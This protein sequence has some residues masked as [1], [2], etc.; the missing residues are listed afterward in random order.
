ML[1]TTS[2]RCRKA[3]RTTDSRDKLE[4]VAVLSRRIAK[5]S[6]DA[7]R[8]TGS[9]R[10]LEPV[11]VLSSEISRQRVAAWRV[12][13]S[14]GRGRWGLCELAL[15]S[16]VLCACS[17]A[18]RPVA[19]PPPASSA[20][21]TTTVTQP[22]A[23]GAAPDGAAVI[24]GPDAVP[25]PTELQLL[26]AWPIEGPPGV[27][28][29]EFQ[30]SG[31]LWARGRL[32]AVSDRQD[33]VVFELCDSGAELHAR[34]WLEFQAP[35]LTGQVPGR[36][37]FEGLAHDGGGALLL[38]SEARFGVL[39]VLEA[40]PGGALPHAGRAA[41]L[42]ARDGAGALEPE[43]PSLRELGHAA[44]FFGVPGADLEGITLLPDGG[45][46][47]AAERQPRG[48]IELGPGRES[49]LQVWDMARSAWP[50]PGARPADFSDLSAADGRVYALVRNAHLVVRLNRSA[51]G[52][53]EERAWSYASTENDPRFVY[54]NTTFGLGEGLAIGPHEVFVVLDNNGQARRATPADRRALL[55]R[56]A[57]PN[58]L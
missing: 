28:P 18:R 56:F 6:A 43:P 32:L 58:D 37:D 27:Q 15:A 34:P 3:R 1:V 48:L 17:A 36:L 52:W 31:L 10:K 21:L 14:A 2:G 49:A 22:A 33:S 13:L 54:A 40:A 46:L 29:A 42:G 35:P 57:R 47:F 55:F 12:A 20:R 5:R 11:A 25:P 7:N 39:R 19:R 26:E 41:W 50:V 38:L 45:L 44:G 30:P 24:A 4:S 51:E 16:L 23:G 8:T 9:M 53:R